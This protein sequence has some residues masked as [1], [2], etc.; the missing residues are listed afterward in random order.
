MAADPVNYYDDDVLYKPSELGADANYRKK[1]QLITNQEVIK[2]YR[3]VITGEDD[4]AIKKP[5]LTHGGNEE[6]IKQIGNLKFVE[7]YGLECRDVEG[8]RET[9]PRYLYIDSKPDEGGLLGGLKKNLKKLDASKNSEAILKILKET[10]SKT[11]ISEPWCREITCEVMDENSN[12]E[13]KSQYVAYDDI[14]YDELPKYCNGG[15]KGP[16]PDDDETC[17]NEQDILDF[18]SDTSDNLEERLFLYNTYLQN[19]TFTN[20]ETKV[21]TSKLPKDKIIQGYYCLLSFLGLYLIYSCS[22]LKIKY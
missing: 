22:T 6:T 13:E 11:K 16:P 17:I 3:N 5:R 14:P 4:F 1:K 2:D 20:I 9:K 19:E 18:T 10:P 15:D 7:L 21:D 8:S 12:V